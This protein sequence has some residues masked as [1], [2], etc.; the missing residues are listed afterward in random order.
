[1]AQANHFSRFNDRV[2]DA[3]YS[4]SLIYNS[5]WEDPAVDRQALGISCNDE[6]MVIASAGC[7]ALD[8]ALAEAQRIH[9]VDMNPRQIALVELKLAGIKTL[10]FDDYFQL[11]GNGRHCHIDKLYRQ[12][13]RAELSPFA[14]GYWDKH[15][16]V[17]DVPEFNTGGLYFHGL[18]GKVAQMFHWYLNCRPK[19]K[20]HV[21]DILETTTIEEQREIYDNRISPLMWGDKMNWLLSRQITMSMLGVPQ[22]QTQEVRKQ[23][24]GGVAGFI[25]EAIEYVFRQLPL[26]LNYFW[27]LYLTGR[28]SKECC[29]EYLSDKGFHRL[30]QGWYEKIELHTRSVT[31]FLH[32]T[33]AK[34]S[35]FVL[36]DHMDWMSSYRMSALCEEWEAIFTSA[37]NDARVIFRSAHAQPAYINQISLNENGRLAP[38]SERLVFHPKLA[39]SLQPLDRVHTYA[40]FHIADLSLN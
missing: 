25:R 15:K 12:C 7:N 17:F 3:L 4:R 1:M 21:D 23:H 27:R 36:L 26:N 16:N 32:Q 28:Y 20:A 5:C 24:E 30:K 19:L 9:A 11:F 10:E 35:K 38:L 39:A 40:G 6:V 29:P 34:I 8:Y 22:A 14:K 18:S 37:A 31:K 2:F 13:L 33:E